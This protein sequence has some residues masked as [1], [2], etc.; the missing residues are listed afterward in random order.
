MRQLN[1]IISIVLRPYGLSGNRLDLRQLGT[2]I[3]L[4]GYTRVRCVGSELSPLTVT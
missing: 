2:P 3:D 4:W 1:A